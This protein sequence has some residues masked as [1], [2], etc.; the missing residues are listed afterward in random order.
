[1]QIKQSSINPLISLQLIEEPVIKSPYLIQLLILNINKIYHQKRMRVRLIELPAILIV[2]LI[3]MVTT[4]N[5]VHSTQMTWTIYHKMELITVIN[6]TN[7]ITSK[8][9]LQEVHLVINSVD[10]ADNFQWMPHT[11]VIQNWVWWAIVDRIQALIIHQVHYR[12][13]KIRW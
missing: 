1:M 5:Q 8:I 13:L 6:S 7:K 11:I 3:I 4:Q 2:R 10:K 9:R 12:F